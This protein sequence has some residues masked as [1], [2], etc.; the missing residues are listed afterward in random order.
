LIKNRIKGFYAL[1]AAEAV[2]GYVD[3]ELA[4]ID[5][6]QRGLADAK[7]GRVISHDKAMAE[8]DTVVDASSIERQA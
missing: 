4:I 2:A 7:A 5:G 3:R 6:I 1:L 8:L